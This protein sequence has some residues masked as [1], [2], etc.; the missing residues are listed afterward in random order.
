MRVCRVGEVRLLPR[1][2]NIEAA[3]DPALGVD[4]ADPG[5]PVANGFPS[6]M[7]ERSVMELDGTTIAVKERC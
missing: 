7:W 5:L 1:G 6:F 2:S 3:C 4:G